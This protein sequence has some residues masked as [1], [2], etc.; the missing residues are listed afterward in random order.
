[1]DK[2]WFTHDPTNSFMGVLLQSSIFSGRSILRRSRNGVISPSWA[3]CGFKW[4]TTSSLTVQSR[5]G[6]PEMPIPDDTLKQL[7]VWRYRQ[8]GSNGTMVPIPYQE[9]L[10]IWVYGGSA[11]P[12]WFMATG[13]SFPPGTRV[14]PF[15]G[16][17]DDLP[18]SEMERLAL[19]ILHPE[20][21]I[22]A[23]DNLEE[24]TLNVSADVPGVLSFQGSGTVRHFN[25]PF[26]KGT[27]RANCP[28]TYAMA[29]KW[30]SI[31]PYSLFS[32]SRTM[33]RCTIPAPSASS[34][35]ERIT[36]FTAT[37]RCHFKMG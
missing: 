14:K 15:R 23:F 1:M 20:S 34:K 37:C 18:L 22:S 21:F 27:T 30:G 19:S 25:S 4:T 6:S 8:F 32:A 12:K 28:C 11:K 7:L 13:M 36:S 31:S 16:K 9:R 5:T 35:L 24:R 10:K 26:P 29:A 33:S 2:L 17:P 3:T